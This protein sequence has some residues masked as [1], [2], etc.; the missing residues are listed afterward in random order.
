MSG[1]RPQAGEASVS[2]EEPSSG[3]AT[4]KSAVMVAALALTVGMLIRRDAPSNEDAVSARSRAESPSRQGESG[5]DVGPSHPNSIDWSKWCAIGGWAYTVITAVILV[6]GL[7]SLHVSNQSLDLN[8][9]QFEMSQRPWVSLVGLPVITS[10]LDLSPTPGFPKVSGGFDGASVG[11]NLEVTNSGHSPARRVG[12]VANL[13][14][15]SQTNVLRDQEALCAGFTKPAPSGGQIF[16][17]TLF[18]GDKYTFQRVA[19]F[20]FV[21]KLRE[22]DKDKK[23]VFYA[24]IVGCIDY[25]F[26]FGAGHHQTGFIFDLGK[27]IPVET[28][29][30]NFWKTF[31][32]DMDD[33]PFQPSDLMFISDVMGTGPAT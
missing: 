30:A 6:V 14:D 5:H 13:F 32:L 22:R 28:N 29:R 27:Q 31:W 24:A 21:S 7:C 3:R 4:I 25:Q 11:L 20:Q 1:V 2:G 18:P 8:Q 23:A 19:A 12:V 10:P 33:A 9:R 15:E 16:E 26:M 17:T